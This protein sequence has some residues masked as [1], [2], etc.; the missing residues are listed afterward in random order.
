M[1]YSRRGRRFI[2]R[3]KLCWKDEPI[4]QG[5]GTNRKIQTLTLLIKMMIAVSEP[6]RLISLISKPSEG[7]YPETYSFTSYNQI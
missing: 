1:D 2:G 7:Y 4:L 6:K 5:S 3:P